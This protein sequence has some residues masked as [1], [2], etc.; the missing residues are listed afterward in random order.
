MAS[1]SPLGRMFDRTFDVGVL[2]KANDITLDVR[3][4]L[5]RNAC[6]CS[7]VSRNRLP[8]HAGL[9]FITKRNE[10]ED[11]HLLRNDCIFNDV[12]G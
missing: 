7:Q 10:E 1:S 4:H 6:F 8:P 3:K 12:Q 11:A 9:S 2:L 5:P